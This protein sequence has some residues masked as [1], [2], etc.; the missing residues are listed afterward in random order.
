MKRENVPFY[1]G[2]VAVAFFGMALFALPAK[3][4]E[5]EMELKVA[6][7]TTE[8][9]HHISDADGT[10]MQCV[11]LGPVIAMKFIRENLGPNW[12]VLRISCGPPRRPM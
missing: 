9:T 6:N 12:I 2:C 4:E 3:A 7:G 5:M 1:V 11:M 8:R 10:M